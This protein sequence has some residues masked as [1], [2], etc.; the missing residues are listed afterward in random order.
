M[1]L[2]NGD[3]WKGLF[4]QF[5]LV[6]FV[7]LEIYL[8]FHFVFIIFAVFVD[9][10]VLQVSLDLHVVFYHVGYVL[11]LLD[12]L[13]RRYNAQTSVEQGL[14]RQLHQ[15]LRGRRQLAQLLAVRQNVL[16]RLRKGVD[17]LLLHRQRLLQQTLLR[18]RFLQLLLHLRPLRPHLLKLVSQLVD[19]V[20]LAFPNFGQLLHFICKDHSLRLNLVLFRLHLPEP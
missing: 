7:F 9:E 1:Y 12:H 15:V 10:L 4:Q 14:Q 11:E 19:L 6:F 8:F 2:L 20:I 16:V 17:L 3:L 13:L 18:P 5:F